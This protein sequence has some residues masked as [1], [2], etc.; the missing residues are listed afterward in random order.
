MKKTPASPVQDGVK[1]F[2]TFDLS[3]YVDQA[4]AVQRTKDLPDLVRHAV[5][6]RVG[7]FELTN[8]KLRAL[9]TGRTF[10]AKIANQT[11]E[12]HEV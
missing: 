3:E 11:L 2:T 8:G 6:C 12:L 10:D 4:V 9:E 1:P 7:R 5:T